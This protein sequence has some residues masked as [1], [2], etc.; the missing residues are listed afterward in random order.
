MYIYILQRLIHVFALPAVARVSSFI[1][2]NHVHY[3][4]V[5]LATLRYGAGALRAVAENVGSEVV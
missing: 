2:H 4:H 1:L 5:F 3:F